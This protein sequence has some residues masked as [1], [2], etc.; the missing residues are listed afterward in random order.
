MPRKPRQ[1]VLQACE[2]MIALQVRPP[3][4][5]RQVSAKFGISARQVHRYVQR[6]QND[7]AKE[8]E[9]LRPLR[10]HQ[11]RQSLQA[12]FQKSMQNNQL[13]AAVAALDRLGKLDGLF[14]PTVIES[15][16]T[17]EGRIDLMTSDQQRKRLAELIEKARTKA[18]SNG[19]ADGAN[20]HANG[21]GNGHAPN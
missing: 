6:V 10:K 9:E 16:V 2:A 7:L 1:D 18:G 19:H 15:K 11:L 17:H 5:V 8:N 21:A 3:E 12:V 4:I 13:S 20:G 14:E